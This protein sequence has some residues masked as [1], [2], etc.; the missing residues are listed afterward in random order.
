[1]RKF[2]L[3]F[4]TIASLIQ[5]GPR[6]APAVKDLVLAA[7]LEA[8]LWAESPMLFNP[9]NMDVDAKGRIWV[10]EAVNY[11]NYNNDSLKVKHFQK[12]DRVVIHEDSDQN[13]AAD[14]STVFVQDKDL[15]SP[16][17]IAVV[18][19]KVIV[20]CSPNMIVYTDTN[21]DDK[22]DK[23]EIFLTGFGGLDHD[24]ALHALVAGPDGR[25]YFNTGNAGPHIVTDKSGWTLRSGSIYTGGSPYNEKN[26]G[27][28]K[29]DDGKVW[30]G[31]L[32]LRMNDDGTGLSVLGHNFRNDYEL[33]TDS[34][35]NLWQNDNDD[36]VVACRTSWLM[37]GGNAGYFSSDGT[38]YWNADQRPW[39]DMF[40]A[41]WHQDD[42]GVMPAGDKTGAGAPTGITVIEGDELGESYRGTVL[43]A[44]AGRNVIFSY[45]PSVKKS[46]Y[47][48][49]KRSNL[50]T[51]LPA[52]NED[53]VWNDSTQNYDQG[54]W[55]RPSDVTIGTDGAIYVAD[56]Y[57]P[58][59]GGHQMDD[60][61]GYGRIYRIAP[62]NKTLKNPKLDFSSIEGLITVLKS[63]AINVRY[64]TFRV[65]TQK[66]EQAAPAAKEMLGSANPYHR[67]RAIWLLSALGPAGKQEV[68]KLLSN[69][70][71]LVRATAFRALRM[72]NK[73]ILPT[74]EQLA[75]DPS[76]FVQRELLI[77]LRDWPYEEKKDVVSTVV[78]NFRGDDRWFEA[79]FAACV[80]GHEEEWYSLLQNLH[81]PDNKKPDAWSRPMTDLMWSIHPRASLN[82]WK[83]RAQATTLS[84]EERSHA[85]TAIAFMN[86][87]EAATAM[88]TLSKSPLKD[89]AE[90]ANY[91][92][93]FRQ[94][95]DWYSLL[96]WK[97]TG[98]NLGRERTL[99]EM[100]VRR[101]NLLD[102]HQPMNE[103]IG[104]AVAMAKNPVGAQMLLALLPESKFPEKLMKEIQKNLLTNTD[105]GVRIQASNYFAQA[106]GGKS[107]SITAVLELPKNATSGKELFQT[108]CA[109][110]H[111]M[112]GAG[113]DIGPE[114]TLIRKKFDR[115]ALLDAIVNPSAGI[116][117]GYEGWLIKT[118]E[119]DTFFG[120]IVADGAETVVI[121]DLT[122]TRQVIKTSSIVSRKKQEKSLM[123]EPTSAGL[124]GQNLADIAEYL[125]TIKRCYLIN[126]FAF[127]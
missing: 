14:K 104:N 68:E 37:E 107:L 70:D 4:T 121:K 38:R 77:A 72:S 95:N 41:H 108:H 2:F 56:W 99:A 63:P 49:G 53:Y 42:P 126:R 97:K 26:Q 93:A 32:A 119:G 8:T 24:H 23:K 6:K 69:E 20:S 105:L 31:G 127:L 78:K 75:N 50:I 39:Q 73:N 120:F 27:N 88:L 66:G 80:A 48:L 17:G 28:Q 22:P 71:E 11:R 10:T 116:V 125:L 64:S 52:D 114:L 60:S 117:F 59:V 67:A 45:R 101:K 61:I 100:K 25:W 51:S 98:V 40:A 19:N 89:V 85:L 123:P 87:K 111:K 54:K 35:G 16:L 84:E 102:E 110:C 65:L 15:V 36:Q 122:G 29:S 103:K 33:I 82:D 34:Y 96:D 3:L 76:P 43:S 90:K 86:S 83:I 47:D 74:A 12:G 115:T 106:S 62:K 94:S 92:L 112:G 81:N 46:G 7:D 55:F 21:G 113:K 58:V 57:D 1:M 79:T 44:D 109:T 118:K 91:W 5:C 124:S 9:T 30:V 13:G 18:G